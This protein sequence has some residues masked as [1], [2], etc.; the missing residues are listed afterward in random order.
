MEQEPNTLLKGSFV[1]LT[2]RRFGPFVIAFATLAACGQIGGGCSQ[3]APIP[4]GFTG[5]MLP[6]AAAANLSADGFAVINAYSPQLLEMI[7]PGGQLLVPLP[8]SI[9][10]A[11]F[12]NLTIGDEGALYCTAESCG[13]LDGKCDAKDVPKTIL[14]NITSLMLAP[15]GPDQL[16]AAL[17]LT[18][19]TGKIMVSSVDR[20]SSFCFFSSPVKCS[21]DLD[22]TRT[23]PL[24][25]ELKVQVRFI[26]DTRWNQVLSFEIPDIGGAKAC[27]TL[28][29]LPKPACIDPADMLVASEGSCGF[30][31]VANFS[32]V[33]AL[34]VDQLTK[35]LKDKLESALLNANCRSCGAG[36]GCPAS[37]VATSS[38]VFSADAGNG[39]CVDD[40]TSK[41]V[42]GSIGIEGRVALDQVLGGLVPASA[43]VDLFVA[44]GSGAVASAKGMTVGFIGGTKEIAIA[45]CVKPLTSPNAPTLPLPDFAF[46][47]PAAYDVGFSVSQQLLSRALFHAQQAGALCVELGHEQVTELDS[48]LLGTLLP[49]L[50]LLTGKNVSVP[51]RVVIRP[52]NPPRAMVGEGTLDMATMKPK[53]PLI[54]FDWDGVEVDLYAK[55]EERYVRLFTVS[56]DLKLP[57]GLSLSGCSNLTPVVGDLSG[58]ITNV[59]AKNSEILAEQLTAL[60]TLVPSLLTLAEPSL[61]R[62]FPALTVP[63]LGG[64]KMKLIASKGVGHISGTKS[65][66][67]VGVYAKLIP[68]DQTCVAASPQM[69]ASTSS[70]PHA[71][72]GRMLKVAA[73]DAVMPEY[74]FRVNGGFWSTWR[75]AAANG[76]LEVN[77]PRLLLRAAHRV[78]V[79][80]RDALQPAAISP[81]VGVTFADPAKH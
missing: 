56:A 12:E 4:G 76:L 40:G 1:L 59:K 73:T 6:T 18:L 39:E 20:T 13:Q 46:D 55:L 43:G 36:T 67:H 25:N 70:A 57:I 34:I 75:A 16:E 78:E 2:P 19:A 81:L 54:R 51:M 17:N 65:Y 49:S 10:S 72:A 79:R 24:S 61:A 64:W 68:Y 74:Q 32:L 62:G 22:T 11:L 37:A 35:S 29:A 42:P 69:R 58:A 44:A 45:Q 9:Q 8:C 63:Q 71:P 60:E 15:K 7:A 14:G 5:D 66:N 53:E 21:V 80:M 26:I 52:V 50:N 48:A 30:C 77:H 27:G 3:L 38:C 41:C 33:K 47:A 31:T 23:A 28:G